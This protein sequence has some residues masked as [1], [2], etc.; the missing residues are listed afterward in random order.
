MLRRPVNPTAFDEFSLIR[1]RANFSHKTALFINLNIHLHCPVRK[2][3][4]Q[5]VCDYGVF[6]INQYAYMHVLPPILPGTRPD[7]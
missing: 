5:E 1:M 4:E 2:N 6:Q 3:K 7:K